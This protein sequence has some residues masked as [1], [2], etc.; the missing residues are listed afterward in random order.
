VAELLGAWAKLRADLARYDPEGGARG[1]W[2][3]ARIAAGT[4]ATW[5]IATYRLGQFLQT[6]ASPWVRTAA[7]VPYALLHR[8]IRKRVGV[9]LYPTTQIGAGLY[10]GHHGG[11]WIS[12]WARIGERCNINHE[13]TIGV[14]ANQE[15]PV[16][17]DRVWIGPKATITGGI[18]VG[19]GAVISAN[20]LVVAS[21]PENGVAIGV[22]A[23][24]ISFAGSGSLLT[25]R[26]LGVTLEGANTATTAA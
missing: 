21:V 5:A 6:E 25:P 20:S 13:V 18:C 26:P 1:L 15:A 22:P 7:R 19:S 12:P 14:A 17:G 2:R 3:I 4:E 8:W 23:R 24:V 10:I 16:I 11:V 9:H